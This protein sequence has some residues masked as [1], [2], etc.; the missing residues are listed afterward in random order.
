MISYQLGHSS[1]QI[2]LSTYV[3]WLPSKFNNEVDDLDQ[4]PPS[5][6][7]VHLGAP[8]AHPEK[9]ADEYL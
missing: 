9:T 6:P 3:H 2:T 4:V 8:Q 7:Q 5:V 1:I